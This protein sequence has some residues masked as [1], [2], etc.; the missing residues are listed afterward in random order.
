MSTGAGAAAF[1]S[2][3]CTLHWHLH[4]WHWH[5]HRRV[6]L[7]CHRHAFLPLHV[8]SC[9]TWAGT[10]RSRSSSA[11]RAGSAGRRRRSTTPTTVSTLPARS[12]HAAGAQPAHGQRTVRTPVFK[13]SFASLSFFAFPPC[14]AQGTRRM[15]TAWSSTAREHPR[16][17]LVDDQ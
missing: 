6:H 3:G 14:V 17:T 13:R 5:W 7:H 11:T 4:R 1:P 12:Q 2:A 9:R 10:A 15:R 8:L 16:V